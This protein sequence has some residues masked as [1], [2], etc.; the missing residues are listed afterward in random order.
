[1]PLKISILR[2]FPCDEGHR[3]HIVYGLYLILKLPNLLV[4]VGLINKSEKLIVILCLAEHPVRIDGHQG[5]GS[6]DKQAS[7]DHAHSGKGHQ[8]MGKDA[9]GPLTDE[10]AEIKPIFHIDNSPPAHHWS[11]RRF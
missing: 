8:A 1:M 9:P 10:V 3:G 7:H 6:H 11:T 4:R 5:E 2:L